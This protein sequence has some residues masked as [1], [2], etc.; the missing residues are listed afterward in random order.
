MAD[1][2][3]LLIASYGDNSDNWTLSTDGKG[4]AYFSLDTAPWMSKG[5]LLQVWDLYTLFC[6]LHSACYV[7]FLAEPTEFLDWHSKPIKSVIKLFSYPLIAILSI[8]SQAFYRKREED[9]LYIHHIR[10]PMYSSSQIW[11]KPFYSKSKSFLKLKA[12]KDK[13]SC[14][15]DA[16]IKAQYIIQGEELEKNQKSLDFFYLVIFFKFGHSV[17]GFG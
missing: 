7:L 1:D 16:S 3:V 6:I 15:T 9:I 13:L 5:V 4:M 12:I 2:T 10:R 14:D 11:L 8:C 17:F